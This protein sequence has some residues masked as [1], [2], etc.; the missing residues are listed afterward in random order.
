MPDGMFAEMTGGGDVRVRLSRQVL[1]EAEQGSNQSVI[2][3]LS[4]QHATAL[5]DILNDRLGGDGNALA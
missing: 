2:L 5:R 1:K 4:R 3:V